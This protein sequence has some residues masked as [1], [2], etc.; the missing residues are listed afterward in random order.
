MFVRRILRQKT[1]CITHWKQ[2]AFTDSLPVLPAHFILQIRSIKRRSV[3]ILVRHAQRPYRVGHD[4]L[5]GGGGQR[6]YRDI[7]VVHPE[8][9]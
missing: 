4:P 8:A 6:H 9:A 5:V 2:I 7:R 3:L 1:I